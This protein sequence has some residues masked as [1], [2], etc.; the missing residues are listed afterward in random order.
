MSD[1]H[2][3]RPDDQPSR[4]RGNDSGSSSFDR[5]NDGARRYS[6]DVSSDTGDIDE[7]PMH[8]RRAGDTDREVPLR[9]QPD[10]EVPELVDDADAEWIGA[11]DDEDEVV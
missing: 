2:Q 8:N 6:D 3:Q 5:G 1:K 4:E 7:R 9:A 11:N 10:R